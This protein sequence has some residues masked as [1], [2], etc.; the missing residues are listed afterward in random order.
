MGA[1]SLCLTFIV[2]L[3]GLSRVAS[4][5]DREN[6]IACHHVPLITYSYY[7]YEVI[8]EISGRLPDL[9]ETPPRCWAFG[10]A[11]YITRSVEMDRANIILYAFT[12]P[13]RDV[14]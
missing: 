11:G 2:Q 7:Q 13:P 10:R 12:H 14:G 3:M 8:L 4:G 6:E 5:C 1:L 9:L